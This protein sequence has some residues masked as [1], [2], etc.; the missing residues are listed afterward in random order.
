M[1]A[2]FDIFLSYK[3][4]RYASEARKVAHTLG[5]QGYRVWFDEDVLS[6]KGGHGKYYTKERLI[7]ILT[8]AVKQCRCSVVFEAELEK[9]VVPPGINIEEE[10]QKNTIMLTEVGLIAWNWQKLEIDASSKSI[11][12]HP[13][14]RILFVFDNGIE[15]S[16]NIGLPTEPYTNLSM[17][18]RRILRSL[19]YFGIAPSRQS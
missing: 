5:A 3:T 16:H 9:V 2:K 19:H 15:V 14:S 10:C 6:S 12:I 7:D 17:L 13:S 1:G 18:L 11:A 8:K 4:R